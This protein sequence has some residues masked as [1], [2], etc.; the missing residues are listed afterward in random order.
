MRVIPARSIAK[1]RKRV[2]GPARCWVKL[3][4]SGVQNDQ[5][6]GAHGRFWEMKRK[7]EPQS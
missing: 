2:T 4:P 1:A 6:V 3:M 5:G 7:I